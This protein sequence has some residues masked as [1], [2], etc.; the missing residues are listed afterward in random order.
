MK[1]L[2]E[3]SKN[4][5]S[6]SQKL[7]LTNR[8]TNLL[9]VK[10]LNYHN[11]LLKN[12]NKKEKDR[13]RDKSKQNKQS[14]KS[15]S[16]PKIIKIEKE[17]KEH[18]HTNIKTKKVY[19]GNNNLLATIREN[20]FKSKMDKIDEIETKPNYNTLSPSIKRLNTDQ[21]IKKT[22][23]IKKKK[24]IKNKNKNN[25]DSGLHKD[26]K[27]ILPPL[28]NNNSNTQNNRKVI[29]EKILINDEFSTNIIGKNNDNKRSLSVKK[30]ILKKS[31]EYKFDSF[32][33]QQK[34][35]EDTFERIS[36]VRK[37]FKEKK[38]HLFQKDKCFYV[39]NIYKIIF[40]YFKLFSI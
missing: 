25:K 36:S 14:S 39:R 10:N 7:P 13:D 31:S 8:S 11:E 24:T 18:I 29:K 15:K 20:K 5:L 38:L 32:Y 19:K 2:N 30:M 21:S 6:Q 40:I 33:S 28:K 37:S 16:L 17:T 9:V 3:P 35:R 26:K 22:K 4:K 1:K 12:D 23:K 27:M 34:E